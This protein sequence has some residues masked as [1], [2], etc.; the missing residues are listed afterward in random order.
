MVQLLFFCVHVEAQ[1]LCWQ[2]NGSI[3][4]AQDDN[5]TALGHVVNRFRLNSVFNS[6]GTYGSRFRPDA[7]WNSNGRFGNRFSAYSAMNP[8]A[9]KP[10]KLVKNERIIGYLTKNSRLRNAVDPDVLRATCEKVL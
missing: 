1:S 8:N 7:I 2:V 3:I 10:P 4:V 9:T 6:S 5:Q